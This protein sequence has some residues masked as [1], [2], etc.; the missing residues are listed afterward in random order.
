MAHNWSGFPGGFCQKCGAECAW[1]TALALG[2]VDIY[3]EPNPEG[4]EDI[5]V[6]NWKSPL[7]QEFV[8]L[9]DNICLADLTEDERVEHRRKLNEAETKVKE[10]DS[11]Y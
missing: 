11:E 1:E 9:C 7:Y 3:P 2:W 5:C 10:W 8:G 6:T 4:G